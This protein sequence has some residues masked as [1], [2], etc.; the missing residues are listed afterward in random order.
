MPRRCDDAVSAGRMEKANQFIKS[1]E[2]IGELADDEAE[3][4]DAV[5]TLLVHA[6]I[7]AGDVICCKTIGQYA[8]GGGRHDEAVALLRT[9]TNPDGPL[10]ARRLGQLLS[11]KTKAGYTHRSVTVD[12][13]KRASRAANDLVEAAR[14]L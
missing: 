1:A 2:D 9:V 13:R 10:L 7:A 12:E 4:R 8:I 6:G 14:R 5:V 11:V 3:V